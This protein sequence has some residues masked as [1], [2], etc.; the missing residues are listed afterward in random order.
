MM[1]QIKNY[2]LSNTSFMIRI[3]YF[4]LLSTVISSAVEPVCPTKPSKPEEPAKSNNF[5][6]I[7][8]TGVIQGHLLDFL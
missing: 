8:G 4:F 1:S 7:V 2:P 6:K 5:D 3:V